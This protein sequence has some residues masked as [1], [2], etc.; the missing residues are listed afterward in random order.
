[1]KRKKLW[2]AFILLLAGTIW[3]GF[4]TAATTRTKDRPN[5]LVTSTSQNVAETGNT[6]TTT[7]QERCI[8]MM[9]DMG[10]PDW[11]IQHAAEMMDGM[12][13][14]SGN[15]MSGGMGMENHRGG[16]MMGN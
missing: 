13:G 4:S 9:T 7:M 10:M 11:M 3:V 16:C 6:G 5:P 2:F 15:M 12:S 14:S 8:A 1:M